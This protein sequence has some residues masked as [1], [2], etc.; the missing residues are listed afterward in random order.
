MVNVLVLYHSSYGH[1]AA[2]AYAEAEGAQSAEAMALVK[3]GPELVPFAT[4]RKSG[5]KLGQPAPPQRSRPRRQGAP[6]NATER[7]TVAGADRG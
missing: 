1:V 6:E 4:A 3:R 2:M 5:F 7:G